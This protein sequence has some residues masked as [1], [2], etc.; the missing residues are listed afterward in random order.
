MRGSGVPRSAPGEKCR[1]PPPTACPARPP[2]APARPHSAYNKATTDP[3]RTAAARTGAPASAATRRRSR[4]T[5]RASVERTAPDVA[6]SARYQTA[7]SDSRRRTDESWRT[8][9]CRASESP[10]CPPRWICRPRPAPAP[11]HGC[12]AAATDGRHPPARRCAPRRS[13]CDERHALSR[14]HSATTATNS[15]FVVA[16]GTRLASRE[17]RA[18]RPTCRR[19][20][21]VIVSRTRR[22]AAARSPNSPGLLPDDGHRR[23]REGQ[24]AAVGRVILFGA[25]RQRRARFRGQRARPVR[26]VP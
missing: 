5:C 17:R 11:A 2:Y 8:T 12:P 13:G 1:A 24:P 3:F 21:H 18:F 16:T 23:C 19:V 9:R 6:E 7:P 4:P 14:R 15:T 26:S 10:V 25:E 22:P 20:P